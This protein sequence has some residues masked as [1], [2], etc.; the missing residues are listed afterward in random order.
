MNKNP[1]NQGDSGGG[2]V[3]YGAH[4]H[5]C[6]FVPATPRCIPGVLEA[7]G[8]ELRHSSRVPPQKLLQGYLHDPN[9]IGDSDVGQCA[10]F[11]QAI[12]GGS[13]YSQPL[14]DLPDGQQPPS[15]SGS[16]WRWGRAQQQ[17]SSKNFGVLAHWMGRLDSLGRR[18]PS[19]CEGL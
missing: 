6:R 17:T 12:H 4:R 13:A 5:T 18:N 2:R 19:D 1:G 16:R 9:R 14:R 8:V 15:R 10:P 7:T 11:A 3:M